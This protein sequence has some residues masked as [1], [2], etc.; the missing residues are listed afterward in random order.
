MSEEKEKVPQLSP[1]LQGKFTLEDYQPGLMRI[2]GFGEVDFTTISLELA[3]QIAKS[4]NCP[5]L[6][7]VP[8]KPAKNDNK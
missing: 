1:A 4:G 6:V 5:H 8:D 3:Q 7:A 2:S